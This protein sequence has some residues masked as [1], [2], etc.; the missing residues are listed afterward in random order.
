MID[1]EQLQMDVYKNTKRLGYDIDFK[2]TVLKLREELK[3]FKRSDPVYFDTSNFM[4]DIK[5]DSYFLERFE[6][7]I[8]HSV[9]D[10]IPDMIF[11]LMS[12]CQ[13][14]GR[15]LETLIMNKLRYNRLRKPKR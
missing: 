11:V 1:L 9:D 5:E 4:K 10:E 6:K 14:S 8:K 7:D 12:Y 15:D 3:E 2:S 13:S